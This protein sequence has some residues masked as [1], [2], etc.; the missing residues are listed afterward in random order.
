MRQFL[1]AKGAEDAKSKADHSPFHTTRRNVSTMR[2]RMTA[3][4]PVGVLHLALLGAL[5]ALG[6]RSVTPR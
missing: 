4:N 2:L 1:A 5:G 6:D 3:G